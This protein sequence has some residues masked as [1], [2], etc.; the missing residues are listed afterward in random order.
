MK[1]LN[2]FILIDPILQDRT[3]AGLHLLENVD[4]KDKMARGT[5]LAVGPGNRHGSEVVP[6]PVKEGDKVLFDPFNAAK[7]VHEGKT[8]ALARESALFAIL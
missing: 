6:L 4:T 8:L 7:V 1:P 3:E 5:V 2:N